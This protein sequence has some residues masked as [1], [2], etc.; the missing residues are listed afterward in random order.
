MKKIISI[1]II[2]IFCLISIIVSEPKTII[3]GGMVP[4][5]TS[6]TTDNDSDLITHGVTSAGQSALS[7]TAFAADKITLASTTTIT[8]YYLMVTRPDSGTL[9]VE[10]WPHDSGNN[11]PEVSGSPISG[12]TASYA[13]PG[14]GTDVWVTATLGTP[15]EVSSG[16]YWIVARAAEVDW[17]WD[18]DDISGSYRQAESTNSGTSWSGY[19]NY[20]CMVVLRGCQ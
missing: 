17:A 4:G 20:C 16:T 13:S 15:Q 11:E 12:T 5:G 3:I 1:F 14:S 6:C 8:E 7:T 2:L 9:Y 19:D 18:Y 10:L